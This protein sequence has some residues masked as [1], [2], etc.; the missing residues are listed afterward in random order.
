MFKV[1][2][3]TTITSIG[4]PG[5]KT[6]LVPLAR[7]ILFLKLKV[8]RSIAA[9]IFRKFVYEVCVHILVGFR[10]IIFGSLLDLDGLQV[11]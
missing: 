10:S 1:R 7:P 8:V 4:S 3:M 2:K 5:H 11:V 9:L 6:N